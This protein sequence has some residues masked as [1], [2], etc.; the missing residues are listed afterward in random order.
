M[1]ISMLTQK[2]FARVREKAVA[3]VV[4]LKLLMR[5]SHT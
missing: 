5:A 3:L 1:E 4:S 2:L